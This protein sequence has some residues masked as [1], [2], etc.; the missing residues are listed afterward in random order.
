M[1]WFSRRPCHTTRQRSQK[2]GKR[3]L[4][5]YTKV[6]VVF[7]TSSPFRSSNPW[8]VKIHI[9]QQSETRLSGS[10]T[11][12]NLCTRRTARGLSNTLGSVTGPHT[13]FPWKCVCVHHRSCSE[14]SGLTSLWPKVWHGSISHPSWGIFWNTAHWKKRED[15]PQGLIKPVSICAMGLSRHWKWWVFYF[16]SAV[17]QIGRPSALFFNELWWKR[18]ENQPA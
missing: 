17:N 5:L 15:L 16:Y 2:L 18:V 10:L 12:D 4:T 14:W 3:Y 13:V 6:R 7:T 9:R 11:F 8:A 1:C